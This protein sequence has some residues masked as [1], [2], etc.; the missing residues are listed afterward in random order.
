[1]LHQLLG[2]AVYHKLGRRPLNYGH[3]HVYMAEQLA[4]G[5]VACCQAEAA[6]REL[7]HLGDVVEYYARIDQLAAKGRVKLFVYA[8]DS[9]GSPEHGMGMV[10]Q[11]APHGVVKL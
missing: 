11:A 1:M 8:A 9:L 6:Y 3:S 2:G 7:R 4:G 5:A 10:K